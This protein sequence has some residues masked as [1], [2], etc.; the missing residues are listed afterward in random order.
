MKQ[1]FFLLVIISMTFGCQNSSDTKTKDNFSILKEQLKSDL[2]SIFGKDYVDNEGFKKP[3]IT[4]TTES[5]SAFFA[6]KD[7]LSSLS[8]GF[9]VDIN[10]KDCIQ[11]DL[12]NDNQLDYLVGYV[13][14]MPPGNGYDFNYAIYI[15]NNDQFKYIGSWQA[16]GKNSP[17]IHFKYIK[18][19]RVY[20]KWTDAFPQGNWS[21]PDKEV[22][23]E[24]IGSTLKRTN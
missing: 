5:V 14:S 11:G 21:Q 10:L 3:K 9:N 2:T 1:S 7:E 19:G 24:L 18:N 23:Y 22:V 8:G 17:E 12:N 20:G 16:G 4:E 15:N 13:N 6:S